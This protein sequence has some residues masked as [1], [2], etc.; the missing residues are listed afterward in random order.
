MSLNFI[1][2]QEETVSKT[3]RFDTENYNIVIQYGKEN[4]IDNFSVALNTMLRRI[5]RVGTEQFYEATK[6]GSQT[7]SQHKP[8]KSPQIGVNH[9]TVLIAD[10]K[11]KQ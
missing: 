1:P 8:L 6:V 11:N 7:F 4:D 5:A 9:G 10:E 2:P 3:V